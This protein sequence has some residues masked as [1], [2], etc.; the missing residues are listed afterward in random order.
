MI[1]I[2]IF[3]INANQALTPQNTQNTSNPHASQ[4]IQNC[5]PKT[6]KTA[7]NSRNAL[8]NVDL[9]H[10]TKLYQKRRKAQNCIEKG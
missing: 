6:Q 9:A 7:E 3:I 1:I 4:M 8:K 10:R 5:T 2:T